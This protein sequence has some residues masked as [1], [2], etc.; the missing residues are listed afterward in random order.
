MWRYELHRE[1]M[2]REIWWVMVNVALWA[3]WSGYVEV[4]LVSTGLCGA[5]YNFE[6][7]WRGRFGGH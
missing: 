6:R 1:A 7:L 2:E 3:V 5:L 4:Q